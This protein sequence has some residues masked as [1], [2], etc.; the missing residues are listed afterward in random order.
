MIADVMSET[1]GSEQDL[2]VLMANVGGIYDQ[3]FYLAHRHLTIKCILL[4]K[5]GW[6]FSGRQWVG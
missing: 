5:Q 3:M 4:G 6:K 2:L 1:V